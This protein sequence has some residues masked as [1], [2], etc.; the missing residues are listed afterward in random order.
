MIRIWKERNTHLL[1]PSGSFRQPL[2]QHLQINDRFLRMIPHE[3]AERSLG[4]VRVEAER[5]VDQAV[6]HEPEDLVPVVGGV[7]GVEEVA[8]EETGQ[9]ESSELGLGADKGRKG[10]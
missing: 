3:P 5:V 7:P 6:H 9:V 4:V 1:R 10:R 2:Q 8:S